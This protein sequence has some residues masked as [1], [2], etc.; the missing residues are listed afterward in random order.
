MK[1]FTFFVSLILI[2]GVFS[3]CEEKDVPYVI[4][5]DEIARYVIEDVNARELFRTD[6][7]ITTDVYTMPFDDSAT[8]RDSVIG[9]E[10]LQFEV[11]FPGS[12]GDGKDAD[13]EY[14]LADYGSLGM[15]REAYLV[16]Q[17]K[18]T[19]QTL[20]FYNG[21]TIQEIISDRRLTRYGFY[22]KLGDDSQAY[23]GW[24]LWGFNGVLGNNVPVGVNLVDSHANSYSVGSSFYSDR[25]VGS[26]G[27]SFFYYKRLSE[28]IPIT[29]GSN[30]ILTTRT[31]GTTPVRR[32][33]FVSAAENINNG[34]MTRPMTYIG[35]NADG[36][37]L[38]VDTIKTPAVNSR[39]WNL[40]YMQ[41]F[42]SDEFFFL[43]NWVVPYKVE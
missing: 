39:T 31:S 9:V 14:I 24:L 26:L 3:G 2:L 15:L 17:D 7:L 18:F 16:A 22:L 13:G 33:D 20:R 19:V 29:E 37:Y 38:E 12:N 10:R 25:S 11:V 23:L 8:Y 21:D 27:G 5:E 1:I 41:S 30:I 36:Q 42:K 43:G 34:F 40:V 32:V 28:I 4:D 6:N 35:T